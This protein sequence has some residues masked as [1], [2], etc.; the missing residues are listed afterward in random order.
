MRCNAIGARRPPRLVMA[1]PNGRRPA[2]H[3]AHA[4]APALGCT[5][6]PHTAAHCR[7]LAAT[8][9]PGLFSG[10]EPSL[11]I[12][13][14]TCRLHRG[15]HPVGAP[16]KGCPLSIQRQSR[17]NNG[18]LRPRPWQ[19]AQL[20]QMHLTWPL[21]I[22]PSRRARTLLEIAGGLAAPCAGTLPNAAMPFNQ[23]DTRR[24]QKR[25]QSSSWARKKLHGFVQSGSP[26]AGK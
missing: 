1:P 23:V 3:M 12:Y 25:P 14:T 2:R 24:G 13:N 18:T 9:A 21:A 7:T 15:R 19:Q 6:L 20:Q 4:A 8:S 16:D 22:W 26:A 10:A 17:I 5:T 11:A